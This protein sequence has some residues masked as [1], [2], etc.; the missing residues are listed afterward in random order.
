MLDM[1]FVREN[2]DAVKEALAK[3]HSKIDLD[4]FLEL[5][6]QR[7]EVILSVEKLKSQRNSA[8]Q[9]IGRMKKAGKNADA[10]MAAVRALGEEIA[11]GDAK[12]KDI[13][14][15][16]NAI[17]Y[18][19]PNMPA[20]DVPVGED[21]SDNPEVRRWGEP[22]KFDFEPQAHWD[23]GEKLGIL[24]FDRAAKVTGARFTF[25]K[26]LG[27]RLERAVINFFLDINTKEHGYTEMFTP[28]M[29]N[30]NTLFG[31]GQ[32]PKFAEDMFKL[33]GLDYYL[34][35]TA[36]VPVT[37]IYRDVILDEKQL[38]IKNCAYTQCFRR[39]AGS[40]GKDVRGLN[41]LHEFSK[42]ELV[43]IDK[44]EHSKQSHQEMLDH[45]E[46]L[47]QKLEL[48]YRILRLCGGDISF[49]AAICYDF[50]V[51]SEAQKRWLEVSSVSN[52]DTYQANRLKCRYRDAD[53]KIQ[54][55][56]TLNGSALALPRIVA[57]LLE[58][59]Q[60]EEG[61]RIPKALVP[62]TGFDMIK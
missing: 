16:L 14:A 52:F 37:N 10:Q 2:P 11:A 60:T 29:A 20:P 36:E 17:L 33:E 49:T 1:N 46:G 32:L 8:S 7:R 18:T 50:E 25:Y 45:V 43:R 12:L 56:H 54:L 47:L 57:A 51:Y 30:S 31:T 62:Y 13:E 40:Y 6:K 48:P 41:R 61:I 3:R 34:I 9:E 22:R 4:A 23:I 42:V 28:F 38:P 39:E 55:C 15:Q 27:S 58:N 53:K 24:D 19:I 44:P 35:P 26:G 5:D 21:D 59:N